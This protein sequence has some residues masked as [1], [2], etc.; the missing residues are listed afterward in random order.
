[1]GLKSFY[2]QST[3]GE[4]KNYDDQVKYRIDLDELLGMSTVSMDFDSASVEGEAQFPVYMG[5]QIGMFRPIRLDHTNC[6][7][8]AIKTHS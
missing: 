6:L 7:Q 4:V 8:V 1:M 3:Q 2:M 5:F